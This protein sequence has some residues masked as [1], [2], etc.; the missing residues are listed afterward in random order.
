[1]GK[2]VELLSYASVPLAI[3]IVWLGRGSNRNFAIGSS[4]VLA[5]AV[6]LSLYRPSVVYE[7]R[8]PLWASGYATYAVAVSTVSCI[9]LVA[10]W[11]SF[12]KPGIGALSAANLVAF[13]IGG[14]G[15][16]IA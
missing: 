5:A 13:A 10:T 1:M 11:R 16:W 7:Y 6:A 3:I 15:L 8:G 9:A 14:M 12:N 4:F 2:I